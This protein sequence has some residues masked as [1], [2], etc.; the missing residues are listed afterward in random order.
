MGTYPVITGAHTPGSREESRVKWAGP[1]NPGVLALKSQVSWPWTWLTWPHFHS[2]CY[3]HII[4]SIFLKLWNNSYSHKQ[5]FQI[6][7]TGSPPGGLV[8]PQIKNICYPSTYFKP[9]SISTE[10]KLVHFGLLL[11]DIKSRVLWTTL[12]QPATILSPCVGFKHLLLF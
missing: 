8:A 4:K 11:S 9:K 2:Q 7:P 6:K 1:E 3:V 10:S 12:L 5:G